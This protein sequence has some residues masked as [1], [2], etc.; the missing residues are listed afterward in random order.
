MAPPAT[1]ERTWN[2]LLLAQWRGADRPAV[3]TAEFTWSGDELLARGGG[4]ADWLAACGFAPGDR[5]PALLDESPTALALCVGSALSGRALAPLGTKLQPA[6]LA[7]AAK[8][9]TDVGLVTTPELV[10]VAAEVARL[11]GVPLHVLDGPPSPGP[12]P[13]VACNPDD[14]AFVVHTSGTTGAPK[15]VAV[16]H[17]ALVARIELYHR[18]MGIGPGDRY[19]SASP[20]HHTAGVSMV[21]TVLGCGAAVIPQ[22]WFSIDG[23]R[24]AGK[25][26]VTHAL[27]VPTMIDLLLAEGAL[28]DAHP[29]VL[30][31]GAA[32]IDLQTLAD[33]LAALPGTQFLQIFGQTE[34]SPVTALSPDDHLLGLGARPELLATVGRA[35]DGVELRLENVDD[36]GIGELTVNAAHAF[37]TDADG[38]RRTGDLGRIDAD[39]YVSLHG[40]VNDRIVRGGENI[41]P[42]EVERALAS[43]DGI[44]EVAVVGVPDRRWGEVVKAVIVPTDP[45][46]PPSIDAVQAHCRERLA[47]FKVPAVVEF[48]AELPRN[49]SGKVL[50]RVLVATALDGSRDDDGPVTPSAE[51]QT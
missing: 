28:A 42:V 24:E 47:H 26:G 17:R 34:L 21:F 45:A 3:V 7:V 30:Q 27:L 50:R 25:L 14:V 9:L 40:R 12:L 32:P 4:A 31:Y 18:V 16:R 37:V 35:P 44:R 33:A 22:A 38:W 1:G 46:A 23:W 6:E 5:V 8:D 48:T 15:P 41:Y 13:E 39:G 19:C 51:E 10:G 2:D 43:L 29:R 11:A 49:A 20:F 36:D